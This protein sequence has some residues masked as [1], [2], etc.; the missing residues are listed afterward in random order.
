MSTGDKDII[1]TFAKPVT[2][3]V[4]AS[5]RIADFVSTQLNI[6][7]CWNEDIAQKWRTL[8][9]VGGAFAFCN[10][11]EQIGKA[12]ELVD[13][14]IW[15][16]NDYTIIPPKAESKAESPFRKAFRLRKEAG[17]RPIDYWT[18]IKRFS[19]STPD[20]RYINWNMLTYEPPVNAL[21]AV[22]DKI[23]YYGAFRNNRVNAFDR[24]FNMKEIPWHISGNAKFRER[25]PH[26]AIGEKLERENFY[27]E[28]GSYRL[29]LYVE[30]KQ[31]HKEFHSPANRFYEMLSAG[32]PMV[33]QRE[34]AS[35]FRQADMDISPYIVDNA[36]MINKAFENAASIQTE[37]HTLWAKDY[38]KLLTEDLQ[39]AYA[40]I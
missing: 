19:T 31:S 34:A 29:G 18:T 26:L 39:R 22:I 21:P 4:V 37:Q 11:L 33:F 23:L 36:A 8:F 14:I 12:V 32:L 25:Y 35:T 30:D 24:F 17:K 2:N 7:I 10:V 13:R 16:Q 1:F 27:K 3:G 38:R 40:K 9:I 20:S 6:P 15:I 5:A 28:L